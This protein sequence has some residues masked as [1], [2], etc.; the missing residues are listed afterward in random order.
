[1]AR[2]T[3]TVGMANVI[4]IPVFLKKM[5]SAFVI[6]AQIFFA[7]NMPHVTELLNY[8]NAIRRLFNTGQRFV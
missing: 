5:E 3:L 2:Q 8:A 6:S 4:A 7:L 1:M